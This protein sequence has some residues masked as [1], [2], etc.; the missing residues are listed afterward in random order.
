MC[1]RDSTNALLLEALDFDS[2]FSPTDLVAQEV[3]ARLTAPHLWRFITKVAEQEDAWSEE[4]ITRLEAT[5]GSRSPRIR[6]LI[7]NEVE[8]PAV[9]R[10][11]RGGGKLA[12]GE[13]V[14]GSSGP[15]TPTAAVVLMMARNGEDVLT[16][17][18]D[19]QVLSLIHI[20]EPTRPY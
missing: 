11:L 16:P 20:S 4:L 17:A 10:W 2:V 14:S 7:V 15:N 1:I 12:L 18:D 19:I 6:R 3:L 8:A 5:C 9:T 13:L